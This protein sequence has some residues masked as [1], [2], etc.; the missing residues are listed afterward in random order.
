MFE[1]LHHY[2]DIN[3]YLFFKMETKKNELQEYF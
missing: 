2:R 3:F 1:T